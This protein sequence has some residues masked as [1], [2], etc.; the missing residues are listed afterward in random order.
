MFDQY[1]QERVTAT[2]ETQPEQHVAMD[3]PQRGLDERAIDDLHG[4]FGE[5][6]GH[7]LRQALPD[8]HVGAGRVRGRGWN[9]T[10]CGLPPT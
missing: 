6:Y 1:E 10:S 5:F 7:V 4:R 9:S 3:L 2:P 8:E